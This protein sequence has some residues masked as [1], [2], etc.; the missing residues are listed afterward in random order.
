MILLDRRARHAVAV[1]YPAT[2]IVHGKTDGI[3]IQTM[4]KQNVLI[5]NGL[6]E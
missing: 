4:K 3:S 5:T 1:R 2:G 6:D